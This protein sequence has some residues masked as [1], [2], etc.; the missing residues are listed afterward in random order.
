VTSFGSV[1]LLW[2]FVVARCCALTWAEKI[3][4]RV[5][6]NVHAGRIW[7]AGSPPLLY[8]YINK[9]FSS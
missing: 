2:S 8:A 7:P 6:S 3:L 5:I 1:R 9:N 4:M